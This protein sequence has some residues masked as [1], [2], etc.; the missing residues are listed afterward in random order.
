MPQKRKNANSGRIKWTEEVMADLLSCRK[1]AIAEH[2][3]GQNY[4]RKGYMEIMRLLWEEKGYASLGLTAP[5][6]RDKAVQLVKNEERRRQK[7]TNANEEVNMNE[8]ANNAVEM[9]ATVAQEIN[10]QENQQ[11]SQEERVGHEICINEEA[12][13]ANH[14][15]SVEHTNIPISI[16]YA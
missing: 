9:T 14:T 13:N 7:Y 10:Q 11:E 12:N 2:Q 1:R 6:L 5:N 3:S 4:Q 15:S 16:S 8:E